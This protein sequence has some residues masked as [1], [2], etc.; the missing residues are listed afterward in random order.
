LFEEPGALEKAARLA[1]EWFKEHLQA[2]P[3]TSAVSGR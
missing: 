3:R 1:A 2:Q